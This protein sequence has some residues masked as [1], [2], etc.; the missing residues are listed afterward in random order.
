MMRSSPRTA[1]RWRASAATSRKPSA[2]RAPRNKKEDCGAVA[3]VIVESWYTNAMT[4]VPNLR[5]LP[6]ILL[7]VLFIL[8]TI[9]ASLWIL[10][11]FLPALIWS[12]LVVVSTWP[13][14][15][16]VQKRL[17]GKRGLAVLVMTTALLLVVIVPLALALLTI[18]EHSDDLGER[19]KTLAHAGVPAPPGWVERVP[20]VG[21]KFAADWQAV[22][23]LNPDELQ[24]RI[25]PYAKDAGRWILGKA[26][27]LAAFFLHL[28]LTLIIS[29]L[30][31]A[32][33]EVAA[34]GVRAFARRL[35]GARGEKS[36][37]LAGQSIRAV[38]LGVVVTAF[39][40]AL[41]GGIGLALAGVPLAGL[42]TA[43]MFVLAVAQ[44]GAG[45]VLLIAVIWLYSSGETTTAT[46]FLVWSVF[47]GTIDNV[48]RPFLI[49]SGADLPLILIFAGVIGGLLAFG[50]VGLFIG[51]VVLAVAY[52]EL[53]AWVSE[54]S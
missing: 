22:A 19:L 31:Y 21:R 11:P 42:L 51:P 7:G 12:T 9:I 41:L 28:V 23:A 35:T 46:V 29:A 38:A 14:M 45:P 52:T 47:V 32:K 3:P 10:Q 24:A 26:G 15:L 20:I 6:R 30:L 18:I 48:I 17:W 25:A 13:L 1:A 40:Q 50:V 37:T 8:L 36:V 34:G 27:G 5:E 43:F 4:N 54:S 33:G 2:P 44:I 39:V 16:A 49:K 53:S